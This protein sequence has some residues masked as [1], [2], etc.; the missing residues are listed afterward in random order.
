MS[1]DS[2]TKTIKVSGRF[3]FSVQTDFRNCYHGH[4]P[5]DNVKFVID[6]GKANYIDSSA[7]GMLLMMREHLGSDSS[8]ISIVNCPP[9]IKNILHVAN[10]QTLFDMK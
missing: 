9:E 8:K 7:L 4:T 2:K 5:K 3:D 1:A 10:F 6:M